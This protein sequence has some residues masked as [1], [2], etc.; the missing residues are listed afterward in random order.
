MSRDISITF[1][2]DK[3]PS[4]EELENVIEDYVRWIGNTTWHIDR[5]FVALPGYDSFPFLR[6]GPATEAQRAAALEAIK[7]GDRKGFEVWPSPE[8]GSW[9]DEPCVCV[10][11]RHA[12]DITNAIARGLAEVLARGWRGKLSPK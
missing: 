7:I 8:D 1:A 11:T 12:D 9:K 4:R 10:I 5:F 2:K 6:S 3:K